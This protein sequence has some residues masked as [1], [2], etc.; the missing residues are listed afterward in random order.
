MKRADILLFAFIAILL[1]L[2]ANRS[3][4]VNVMSRYSAA[5]RVVEAGTLDLGPYAAKTTD[6]AVADGK[7]YTDK[8]PGLSL[9]LVP[10][11]ALARLVTHDFWWGLHLARTISLSLATWL[12]AW[13]WNRRLARAGLSDFDRRLC[14]AIFAIG[15]TAWPYF[16]MLYGHGPSALFVFW[17]TVFFLDYR[18]DDRLASLVAS[19]ICYGL[20][21]CVEYPTAVMGACAGVY[22]LT[23][24]RRAHRIALFAVLGALVPAAII[25]N[26]N[27]ALFGGPLTFGYH[28]EHSEF[29]R[30]K[31]SQGLFGIGMPSLAT[32]FLLL[33]SP[34]KGLF[35]WSPVAALGFAGALRAVKTNRGPAL[36]L[37]GMTVAYVVVLS[38]YFEASGSA[39]LGP[40]HLTPLVA[41]LALG[42]AMGL[43]SVGARFRGVAL[44][45]GMV[46][47]LLVAIGIATW[48]QI[49]EQ[50]RNPLWEFSLP[51]LFNGV[52]AGNTLGLPDP[53]AS[54]ILILSGAA[55][56][57]IVGCSPSVSIRNATAYATS[58]FIAFYLGLA[59]SLPPT[60]PGVL[61]QSWGNYW[62]LAGDDRRAVSAY[63]QAM[64]I[65]D[66][67][68]IPY[69]LGLAYARLG[70]RERTEWLFE[71]LER[72]YPGFL[73]ERAAERQSQAATTNATDSQT[74]NQ[75]R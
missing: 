21:I 42:L 11:V 59:P 34:A 23:F 64:Q 35:F 20:A 44:A 13:F 15:T 33:L 52:G 45:A 61:A 50:I 14:V 38:G 1:V 65:R 57:T 39:C 29:Y 6:L 63:E 40:R 2:P 55:V 53:W 28:L 32:A 62:S 31:M 73:S 18:N 58:L 8:A 26:F 36:F 10:F 9:M 49:F 43:P 67:P 60:D 37:A 16:T 22:L 75:I 7:R 24:E 25:L 12:T 51:L 3:V 54:S 66:D 30:E 48:P 69:Y 56:W 68:Y 41:P 71:T 46:S 27:A 4:G 17:A 74:V 47:T 5:L 19:G 70:E 72:D